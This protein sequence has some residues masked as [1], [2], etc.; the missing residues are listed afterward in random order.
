MTT[1]YT[2]ETRYLR[3]EI[4]VE[5]E[6]AGVLEDLGIR[7]STADVQPAR[8]CIDLWKVCAYFEHTDNAGT[9]VLMDGGS[10]FVA[11]MGY[12]EFNQAHARAVAFKRYVFHEQD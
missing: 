7:P 3:T 5:P 4:Y 10:Q 6:A 8:A 1:D 12:D 2:D 11:S 9:N